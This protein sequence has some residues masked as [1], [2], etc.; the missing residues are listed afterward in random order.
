MRGLSGPWNSYTN[1]SN[2]P[3][4]VSIVSEDGNTSEHEFDHVVVRHGINPTVHF[5]KSVGPEFS[6]NA[7]ALSGLIKD[8]RL[9]EELDIETDEYFF[10]PY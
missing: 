1:Q 8:L 3:T 6:K 4:W 7:S 9:T 10:S 2:G 5:E